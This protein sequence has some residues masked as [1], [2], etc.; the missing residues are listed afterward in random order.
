[1]PVDLGALD[2]RGFGN[3]GEATGIVLQTEELR[4][5]RAVAAHVRNHRAAAGQ[6]EPF[7]IVVQGSTP[8]DPIAASAIAQPY[9]DEGATWWIDGEWEDPTP[10]SLA[11]RVAAGPPRTS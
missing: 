10:A 8:G 2:D 11:A 5:I 4:D 3:V 6:S 7:E 1:V 9:A